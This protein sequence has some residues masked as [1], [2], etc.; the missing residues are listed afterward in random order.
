M[1]TTNP[2]MILPQEAADMVYEQ[3]M[4]CLRSMKWLA[5]D[6]YENKAYLWK[7]RPKLHEFDHLARDTKKYR[8]NFR[9]AECWM[10]ETLMAKV[11]ALG[12]KCPGSNPLVRFF[13]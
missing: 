2:D 13:Q 9:F 12:Q 11:K 6:A 10:D 7:L 1:T 8:F 4:L 3:G 5:K